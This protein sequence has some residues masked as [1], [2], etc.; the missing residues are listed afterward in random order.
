MIMPPKKRALANQPNKDDLLPWDGRSE[1]G[2]LLIELVMSNEI[3]DGVSAHVMQRTHKIFCLYKMEAFWNALKR[4][5][6][7]KKKTEKDNKNKYGTTAGIGKY[8]IHIF[9]YIFIYSLLTSVAFPVT[10]ED[11]KYPDLDDNDDFQ[12]GTGNNVDGSSSEEES[13]MATPTKAPKHVPLRQELIKRYMATITPTA[14]TSEPLHIMDGVFMPPYFIT[15]FPVSATD[16]KVGLV[17]NLPGGVATD[18]I[19]DITIWLQN[20]A[21]KLCIRIKIHSFFRDLSFFKQME[22]ARQPSGVRTFSNQ[23]LRS[24]KLNLEHCQ[25][26][27][28]PTV[29][30]NI[31]FNAVIPMEQYVVLPEVNDCSIYK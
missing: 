28:C 19:N 16:T 11:N 5:R 2:K 23:V 18:D 8:R 6:A 4:A 24:F 22:K 31:Y 30:N 13:F 14:A 26:K 7:L 20:E 15:L 9:L 29:S 3:E 17:V 12:L 21:T 27:F 25:V 1:A 10:Q